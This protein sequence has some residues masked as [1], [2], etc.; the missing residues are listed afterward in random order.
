[1]EY[2]IAV[3]GKQEEVMPFKGLGIIPLF[4]ESSKEAEEMLLKMRKDGEKEYAIIFLSEDLFQ[5][6]EEDA[7]EK[8]SQEMLP[9]LVPVPGLEGATGFGEDRMRKFVEQAVGSDIFA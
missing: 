5:G 3:L 9:V 7:L 8:L 6:I 2:K 4:V 1:M